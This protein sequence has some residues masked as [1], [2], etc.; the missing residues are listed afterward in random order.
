MPSGA[1]QPGQAERGSQ[2]KRS[3]AARASEARQ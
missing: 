2:G 3:A 1:R